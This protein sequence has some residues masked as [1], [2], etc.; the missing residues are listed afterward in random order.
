MGKYDF[1]EI[2]SR[3]GTDCVKWDHDNMPEDVFPLLV[4]D[5]D[6]RVAPA[7]TEALRHRVEHGVFGYVQVPEEYYNSVIDWYGRRHDFAIRREWIQY[8]SGV[9]PAVSVC[10]QAFTQPGDK[11]LIMTPVYNCFYSSIA[12]ARCEMVESRLRYD[13]HRYTIDFDD[14]EAKAADPAVKLFVMCN[15]H[16]PAC[17]VW[18]RKELMRVGEICLRHNV[19]VV[20]DEIHCE[21]VYGHNRYTPFGSLSPEM[22]ANSVTCCSPSKTFNTAGLQMANIIC[23][24][25]ARREKIDRVINVN[26][27]CDV[28]PFGYLAVMAA[29]DESEPWLLELLDYIEGNYKALK[30]F[31]AERLPHLGVT[32]LEGTYLAWID[33]R[34]LGKNSE[35]LCEELMQKARVM[36]NAGTLYGA[37]GEGFL[38]INMACPRSILMEALRRITP[39]LGVK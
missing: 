14:F 18:T 23:A 35:T 19:L 38:R 27:V 21:F 9:V 10:V 17:R 6:F 36:L 12:N 16:N 8:T 4:A 33:V 34:S 3:R 1:D 31:F 25:A 30:S 29:Y 28:N 24:D 32:E 37:A 7:I 20:S 13:N 39:Y 5:M 11:V 22:L 2:V 15:P 26:E